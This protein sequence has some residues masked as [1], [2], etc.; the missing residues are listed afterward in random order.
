MHAGSDSHFAVLTTDN[1]LQLDHVDKLAE[2]EQTF[3]FQ[4]STER[5]MV[6]ASVMKLLS[7][8]N[9]CNVLPS[10]FLP[11]TCFEYKGGGTDSV[12]SCCLTDDVAGLLGC[13]ALMTVLMAL[14]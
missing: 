1:C 10:C 7:M 13:T 2:P 5:Y 6:V 14:Y 12:K 3:E 8:L 11:C 9:V 4:T